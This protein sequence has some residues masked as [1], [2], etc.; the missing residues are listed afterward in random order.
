[1]FASLPWHSYQDNTRWP[2]QNWSWTIKNITSILA[3]CW[4]RDKKFPSTQF[5]YADG[6]FRKVLRNKT[7]IALPS[8]QILVWLSVNHRARFYRKPNYGHLFL[9]DWKACKRRDSIRTTLQTDKTD[10]DIESLKI[11]IKCYLHLLNHLPLDT[12]KVSL[13]SYLGII[14]WNQQNLHIRKC[15]LP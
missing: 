10:P 12:L 2:V 3:F 6:Y 5:Q 1:M 11:L 15:Q 14:L 8:D 7:E 4:F 13:R 9:K